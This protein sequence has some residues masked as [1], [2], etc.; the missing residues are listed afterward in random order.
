MIICEISHSKMLLPQEMDCKL[1]W[2]DKLS[3]Q[4]TIKSTWVI[5]MQEK[6]KTLW[7]SVV[8]MSTLSHDKGLI[9]LSLLFAFRASSYRM[10]SCP[11]KMMP[12]S[13]CHSSQKPT[14]WLAV[15]GIPDGIALFLI[16]FKR[17]AYVL[18]VN[19]QASSETYSTSCLGNGESSHYAV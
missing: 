13:P 18:C 12:E 16:A 8:W 11:F 15:S 2:F 10:L 5:N 1:Y 6:S 17:E 19:S 4:Y 9:R 3:Y 14:I 7:H